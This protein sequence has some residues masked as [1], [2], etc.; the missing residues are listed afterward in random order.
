MQ[1]T[2]LSNTTIAEANPIFVVHFINVLL[3]F[4]RTLTDKNV[5]KLCA[6]VE[7]DPFLANLALGPT[8]LSDNFSYAFGD[9]TKIKFEERLFSGAIS[10]CIGHAY[11]PYIGA[12]MNTQLSVVTGVRRTKTANTYGTGAKSSFFLNYLQTAVFLP[13]PVKRD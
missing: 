8:R 12:R 4:H 2:A 6:A 3:S 7:S 13:F 11:S 9:P 1:S 10:P 5:P